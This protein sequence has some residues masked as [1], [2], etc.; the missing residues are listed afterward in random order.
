MI[1][2]NLANDEQLWSLYLIPLIWFMARM[3]P[4]W[5]QEINSLCL[6]FH[7]SN[8]VGVLWRLNNKFFRTCKSI[9]IQT[10]RNT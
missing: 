4:F 7:L 9:E 8:P 10:D 1:S 5:L 6:E 3:Y 2:A